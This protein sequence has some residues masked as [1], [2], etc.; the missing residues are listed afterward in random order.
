MIWKQKLKNED[1]IDN[2]VQQSFL[3]QIQT[4]KSINKFLYNKQLNTIHS[5]SIIKPHIKW[6]TELGNI[7]WK[8]VHTMPF[9]SLIDTKIRTFQYKYLMRIVPNNRFLY[10]CNISNIS[11]VIFVL[12]L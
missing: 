12:C 5:S 10:K 7:N 9:K 8:I 6:E 11:C 3:Q 2:S 1:F 4:L